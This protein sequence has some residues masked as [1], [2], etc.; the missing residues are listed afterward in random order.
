MAAA[1]GAERDQDEH[2]GDHRRDRGA[3]PDRPL[4]RAG[5]PRRGR[6]GSRR[7]SCSSLGC[8]QGRSRGFGGGPLG[9]RRRARARRR[10]R[11]PQGTWR[12]VYR[13]PLRH[14]S[15]AAPGCSGRS[16]RG[17]KA[18]DEQSLHYHGAVQ[19]PA[20]GDWIAVTADAAAGRRR[21]RV[22]DHAGQRRGRRVP[23][24]RPRPLRRARRRARPHLRGLRGRGGRRAR[25]GR[26][27]GAA[28]VA[29][30]STAS[31]CCTAP[32]TSSSRRRRSRSSCRRRTGPRRSRRPGS[33]ST[34]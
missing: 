12:G 5:L 20:T 26:R 2:G 21:H 1:E 17:R 18:I 34:R 7:T 19:P 31:R 25:G 4:P 33:A 14:S 15:S 27:R 29:G 13:R 22:G 11:P 16:R 24:R 3:E 10:L 8:T 28:A 6:R 32:A 30:R 23:R 9:R